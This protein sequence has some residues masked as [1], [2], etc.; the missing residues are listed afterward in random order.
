LKFTHLK[1]HL[2]SILLFI[3]LVIIAGCGGGSSSSVTSTNSP[4]LSVGSLS[5]DGTLTIYGADMDGVAT[6]HFTLGCPGKYGPHI[7]AGALITGASITGSSQTDGVIDL[8]IT[9]A[10]P[11]AGSGPVVELSFDAWSTDW[12]ITIDSV[13]MFDG[14]GHLL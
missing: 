12:V 3:V 14:E 5:P 13:T 10:T 8:T 6:I 11:F 7:T 1:K 9:R 2:S 4:S